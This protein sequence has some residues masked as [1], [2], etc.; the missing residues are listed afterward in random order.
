MIWNPWKRWRA[1]LG[2]LRAEAARLQ[3]ERDGFERA[4]LAVSAERDAARA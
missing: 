1:E 3:A 2:R 4:H